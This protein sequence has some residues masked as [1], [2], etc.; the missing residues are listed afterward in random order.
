MSG[1]APAKGDLLVGK[2]FEPLVG[3]GDAMGV[4]AQIT[5]YMLRASARWFRVDHP[6][7]SK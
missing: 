1:V 5:E 3:D 7:L 4:T 6:I 2:R